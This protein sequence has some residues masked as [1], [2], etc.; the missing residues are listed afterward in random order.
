M[1]RSVIQT[2]CLGLWFLGGLAGAQSIQVDP[3]VIEE[4]ASEEELAARGGGHVERRDFDNHVQ[5]HFIRD[6][7]THVIKVTP[8]VGSPYYLVDPDGDGSMG[9][10][11]GSGGVNPPRWVLKSW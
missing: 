7:R 10:R 1:L 8:R 4:V 3:A 5:E 11:R 2:M 9:M 6:G